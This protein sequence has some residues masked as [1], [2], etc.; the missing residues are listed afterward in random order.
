MASATERFFQ[1]VPTGPEEGPDARLQRAIGSMIGGAYGDMLGSAVEWLKLPEIREKYGPHGIAVPTPFHIWPEP[2]ITDD[3]QMAMSTARGLLDW[4]S[5]GAARDRSLMTAV[6]QQYLAWLKTQDDPQLARGP[7]S[8]CLAALRSGRMGTILRPLNE[9]AGCGGIMRVHPVGIAHWKNPQLA[10]QLGMDIAAITHGDPRGYIPAGIH[11]ALIALLVRGVALYDAVM[12]A[13]SRARDHK[14]RGV[15]EVLR[16]ID[17]ALNTEPS[18]ESPADI[19]DSRLGKES[20][21]PG[22]WL[23]H[24]ALAIALFAIFWPNGGKGDNFPIRAVQ[25]AVNHSGDSDSTG[26]L[27]GAIL[28][29]VYGPEPFER[30]LSRHGIVLEHHDELIDLATKLVIP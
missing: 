18:D 17:E 8:T 9:G 1:E 22:G 26:A 10:F 30:E 6:Y 28:G 2:V 29:A 3:T 4:R 23:G 14:V 25:I 5:S 27:A 21:R 16:T 15:S 20:P 24:D 11:A 12:S 13:R 19:I 7:G